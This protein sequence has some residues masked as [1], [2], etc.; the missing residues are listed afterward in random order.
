MPQKRTAQTSRIHF[1]SKP[2]IRWEKR[3]G[4]AAPPSLERNMLS[5]ET[6]IQSASVGLLSNRSACCGLLASA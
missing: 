5:N 1:V 4:G 2:P 6:R 3:E